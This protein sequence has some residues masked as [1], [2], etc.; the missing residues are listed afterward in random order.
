MKYKKILD[1]SIVPDLAYLRTVADG[2]VEIVSRT[3]DDNLWVVLYIVDDGP[4]RF[5]LYVRQ[6]HVAHFLFTNRQALEK[7]PLVKMHSTVIKSRDGLNLVLYYSL[8]PGSD[9]NCDGIPDHPIPMVFT[10][11]GGPWGRDFWG[12]NPRHQWLSNR[13]YAVLCVNFRSSTGFG[14]TFTN[15]GDRQWGGKI[16]EDQIDAVQW[17]I[18]H[19]I[20]DPQKVVTIGLTGSCF[21]VPQKIQS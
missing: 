7:L 3:L 15:A 19:G 6:Q 5:Y 1:Q 17:A 20:A 18:T 14:K 2:E 21:P 9:Y 16:I 10:P 12:Y 13:G 4:T 8:P 11:H